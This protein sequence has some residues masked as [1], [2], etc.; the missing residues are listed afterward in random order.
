[1]LAA[2]V[3]AAEAVR[4]LLA[5]IAWAERRPASGNRSEV[6]SGAHMDICRVRGTSLFIPA[7]LFIHTAY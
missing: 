6:L 5:A 4:L 7:S 2:T 3:I 1:M